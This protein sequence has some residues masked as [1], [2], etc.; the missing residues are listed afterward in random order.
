MGLF[1][2]PHG[3]PVAYKS[4]IYCATIAYYVGLNA[5][6]NRTAEGLQLRLEDMSIFLRF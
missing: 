2:V 6:S 3:K 5:E 4:Y 1:S